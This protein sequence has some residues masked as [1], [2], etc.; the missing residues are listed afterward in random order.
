MLTVVCLSLDLQKPSEI[1]PLLFLLAHLARLRFGTKYLLYK[2][3][4]NI[5][6]LMLTMV[7]QIVTATYRNL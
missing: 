6:M 1:F 4:V 3:I 5:I 7:A 2:S